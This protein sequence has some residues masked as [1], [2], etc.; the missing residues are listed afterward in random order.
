MKDRNGKPLSRKEQWMVTACL[1]GAVAII[2]FMFYLAVAH[3][4]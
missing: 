2:T 4:G 1:L 3:N